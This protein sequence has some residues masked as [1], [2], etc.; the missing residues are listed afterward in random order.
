MSWRDI[1][2]AQKFRM[3]LLVNTLS[4]ISLI[5]I[6]LLDKKIIFILL[7]VFCSVFVVD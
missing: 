6:F 5:V 2:T 7:F 4:K 3:P 1:A